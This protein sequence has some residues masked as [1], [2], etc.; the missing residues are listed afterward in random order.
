MLKKCRIRKTFNIKK[1]ISI[2]V[3]HNRLN[4][5]LVSK[6]AKFKSLTNVFVHTK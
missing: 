6:N 4:D 3:I 1:N 5:E 2:N